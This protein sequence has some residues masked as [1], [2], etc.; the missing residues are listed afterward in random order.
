MWRDITITIPDFDQIADNDLANL[1]PDCDGKW[2]PVIRAAMKRFSARGLDLNERWAETRQDW[3]C[4]ACQRIKADVLRLTDAGVLL[5]RLDLHHD[6]LG[7]FI[8]KRLKARFGSRWVSEGP[9]GSMQAEEISE[10]LLIRFMWTNVCVDCNGADAAAKRAHP[11]IPTDFSFSPTEIGE[12]ITATPNA[13][14]T[15]D[16]DQALAVWERCAPVFRA[17]LDLAVTILDAISRGELEGSPGFAPQPP[18]FLRGGSMRFLTSYADPRLLAEIARIEQALLSRSISNDGVNSKTAR[19]ARVAAS[20]PSDEAY[21]SYDGG[22]SPK[23]WAEA[24]EDWRCPVCA[25]SKRQILRPGRGARPWNGRLHQFRDFQ[26]SHDGD[27]EV[28]GVEGHEDFLV[29]SGCVDVVA[30]LRQ[31]HP[32]FRGAQHV[33]AS[34]DL[35]TVISAAPNARHEVDWNALLDLARSRAV[36]ERLIDEYWRE[37]AASS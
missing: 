19:T 22:G 9:P 2:S 32:E 12:F 1:L 25:R 26:F 24:G 17:R 35:R 14:H 7:D 29:C 10:R 33:L 28:I 13:P 5:A 8:K 4:P 15:I 31:R 37:R 16:F 34:D 6:H 23:Y 21:A 30:E 36:P 18:T 11:A 3:R 20:P 27:G